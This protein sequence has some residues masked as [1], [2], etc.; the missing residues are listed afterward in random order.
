MLVITRGYNS[1]NIEAIW[2]PQKGLPQP[3]SG[4]AAPGAARCHCD[5]PTSN[6]CSFTECLPYHQIQ[7]PYFIGSQI[8][9][10]P[11]IIP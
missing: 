8:I 9:L 2:R 6:M 11:Y 1:L 10:V 7:F 3:S 4:G 5:K